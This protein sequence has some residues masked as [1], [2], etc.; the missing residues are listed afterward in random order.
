ML[1]MVQAPWSMGTQV[2]PPPAMA[3]EAVKGSVPAQLCAQPASPWQQQ[4]HEAGAAAGILPA[5]APA[6]PATRGAASTT[7]SQ[8][9]AASPAAAAALLG[10]SSGATPTPTPTPSLAPPLAPGGLKEGCGARGVARLSVCAPGQLGVSEGVGV[11][12]Q[13]ASVLGPFPASSLF[14]LCPCVP[15]LLSFPRF[16]CLLL[17]FLRPSLRCLA[18]R[19][20]PLQLLLH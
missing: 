14:C 19:P 10:T 20:L 18:P 17:H 12:W 15:P 3:C 1:C 2:G 8:E 16:S 13:P 4:P 7:S 9:L 11:P 6:A 5:P